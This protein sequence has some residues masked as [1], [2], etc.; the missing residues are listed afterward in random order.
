MVLRAPLAPVPVVLE[1]GAELEG[2]TD[3]GAVVPK[4]VFE[5]DRAGLVERAVP[6]EALPLL[7]P[8]AVLLADTDFDDDG[9]TPVTVVD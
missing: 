9:V 4:P 2:V 7:V 6:D 1:T 5:L 8:E 3:A